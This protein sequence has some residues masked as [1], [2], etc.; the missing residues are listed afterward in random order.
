MNYVISLKRTPERLNTFLNNNRHMDFQI[1][2]AI[3]GSD[4]QPFGNY[5]KYARANALSHIALWKKCA[6]GDED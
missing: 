5:N 4:L 2:D 1:F 6:A 3:D